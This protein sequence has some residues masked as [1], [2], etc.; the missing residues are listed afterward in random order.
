VRG[1]STSLLLDAEWREKLLLDGP[2]RLKLPAILRRPPCLYK[3]IPLRQFRVSTTYRLGSIE[4]WTAQ[5]VRRDRSSEGTQSIFDRDT[6]M[7][8]FHTQTEAGNTTQFPAFTMTKTCRQL[9]GCRRSIREKQVLIN[10]SVALYLSCRRW[11]RKS[12]A[13]GTTTVVRFNE[14][15]RCSVRAGRRIKCTLIV[16]SNFGG[17]NATYRTQHR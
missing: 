13:N 10:C 4:V 6:Q 2:K 7:S 15:R 11:K 12:F 14:Q 8:L 9:F 5:G 17:E 3:L 1:D 16:I